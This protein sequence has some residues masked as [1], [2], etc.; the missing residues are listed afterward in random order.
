MLGVLRYFSLSTALRGNPFVFICL[1]LPDMM[2]SD[3][4]LVASTSVPVAQDV[5]TQDSNQCPGRLDC[6]I[7]CSE[8]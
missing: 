7:L 4:V 5:L 3:P 2:Q 8:F 1:H 6:V